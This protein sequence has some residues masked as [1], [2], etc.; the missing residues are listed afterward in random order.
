MTAHETVAIL[1][2]P[3]SEQ[4]APRSSPLGRVTRAFENVAR[5]R[6]NSRTPEYM[7]AL[8]SGVFPGAELI[9]ANG[10]ALPQRIASANHIVLAWPDAIG[11]GWT[12]IERIVFRSKHPHASVSA[13]SGR[14]R[15]VPLTRRTL[16]AFRLR[17]AAE[18]LWVGEIAAAAALLL[19][20]PFL[21]VWDL[22]KG[23]R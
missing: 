18:R 7:R 6:R 23:R 22:A 20:A 19:A 15:S 14:R 2:F 5:Y 12:P 4:V 3:D 11:H 10:N 13:L 21:V 17:R 1:S 9:E 16:L 8:V